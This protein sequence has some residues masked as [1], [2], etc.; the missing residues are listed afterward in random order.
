MIS[1]LFSFL[2]VSLAIL[3]T[4]GA[5]LY[6]VI[7]GQWDNFILST[8][9]TFGKPILTDHY[10]TNRKQISTIYRLLRPDVIQGRLPGQKRQRLNYISPGPNDVWYIDGYLKLKPFGI[11]IYAAIDSYSRFIVWVYIGVSVSTAVS[12]ERQ[13]LDAFAAYSFQPRRFRSD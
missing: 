5:V 9:L 7:F 13:S 3:K 4:L 1:K 12:V 10:Y 11:E 8:T 6:I 2:R